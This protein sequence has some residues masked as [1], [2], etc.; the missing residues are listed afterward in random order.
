MVKHKQ[1]QV[2]FDIFSGYNFSKITR[3]TVEDTQSIPK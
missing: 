1:Y 3:E 2:F